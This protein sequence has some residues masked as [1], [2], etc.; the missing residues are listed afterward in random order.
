MST[1]PDRKKITAG[2][3]FSR[4]TFSKKNRRETKKKQSP[5]ESLLRPELRREHRSYLIK[6]LIFLQ[7]RPKSGE[8]SWSQPKGIWNILGESDYI[9]R[10]RS[11]DCARRVERKD[12][13]EKLYWRKGRRVACCGGK[14]NPRVVGER[15]V[16]GHADRVRA[17]AMNAGV[18]IKRRTCRGGRR[19]PQLLVGLSLDPH[20]GVVTRIP[21]RRP[22]QPTPGNSS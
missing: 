6:Y 19:G 8:E 7:P 12:V 18:R 9:F 14:K 13:G 10:P 17:P 20:G 3:G 4:T 2:G 5:P 22:T 1:W 16:S 11:K 21:R 15:G